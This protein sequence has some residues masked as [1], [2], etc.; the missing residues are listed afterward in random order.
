[1]SQVTIHLLPSCPL[2]AHF[3]NGKA[4][5]PLNKALTY[6]RIGCCRLSLLKIRMSQL[7]CLFGYPPLHLLNTI[8]EDSGTVHQ[9]SCQ[10][11]R[12]LSVGS[13]CACIPIEGT[14]KLRVS[15]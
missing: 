15:T 11:G 6:N 5:G 3:D 9:S 2:S 12:E 14:A 4:G 8:R 1:M 7:L 10:H 13:S